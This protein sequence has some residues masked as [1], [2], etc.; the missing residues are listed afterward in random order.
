MALIVDL[1]TFAKKENSTAVPASTPLALSCVLKEDCSILYPVLGIDNGSAWNPAAYNYAAITAFQR[2]YFIS[3]WSYKSG[4]WWAQLK[5][6]PL[7]TWKTAI[8]NATEYVMRSSHSYDGAIIDTLFPAKSTYTSNISRWNGGGTGPYTPWTNNLNNGFYVVGI[9]NND[10]DSIGAVSYYAFTPAQF[11]NLKSYLLGSV[12]WTGILTTNPDIGENLFK[13][14]FNPFQYIS[15]VNWFPFSLPTSLLTSISTL[16]FGWWEIE[17]MPCYRVTTYYYSTASTIQVI[18]HPQSYTRGVFLN[19][20]PYSKYILYAPPF[21]TFELNA[22]IFPNAAYSSGSTPVTCNI[23]VDLISGMGR[24]S[25]TIANTS[26]LYT[27]TQI[28]IP[29]Q[30]AQITSENSLDRVA[31]LAEQSLISAA[32]KL[33]GANDGNR[34]ADIGIQDAAAIGSVNMLQIGANGSLCQYNSA[35]FIQA[36]YYNMADD[37]NTDKGRP[38]CQEVQLSTLAPGYVITA[39]SHIAIAGSD[40]EIR[41]INDFLDGGVFLE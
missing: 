41:A 29:I 22:S 13:A 25:V 6:D 23:V 20:A 27:Q 4:I 32:T 10:D 39:G 5:V 31:Y 28:A 33:L 7:A 2:Y 16:K 8:Y 15:T 21:G 19:G 26:Q 30:L 11:A 17:E 40:E 38:L 24:L 1:Y 14:L 18:S 34:I 36:I 35:F 9:I 12:T 3:N 37:A